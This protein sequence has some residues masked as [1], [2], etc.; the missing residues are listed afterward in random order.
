MGICRERRIVNAFRELNRLA[1]PGRF[2]PFTQDEPVAVTPCGP[3]PGRRRADVRL[4]AQLSSDT[5]DP[6]APARHHVSVK[7]ESLRARPGR[8]F[9][10]AAVLVVWLGIASLIASVPLLL[11]RDGGWPWLTSITEQDQPRSATATIEDHGRV[12]EFTGT[13]P[14]VQ[15]WVARTEDELK[16]AHGVPTKIAVGRVLAAAGWTLLGVGIVVPILRVLAYVMG[17]RARRRTI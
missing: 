10:L 9:W 12:H 8:P 5:Q 15:A 1:R 13:P 7:R 11:L 2:P 17:T 16:K 14:D 4:A 6:V 3:S